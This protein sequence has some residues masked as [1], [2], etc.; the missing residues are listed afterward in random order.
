MSGIKLWKFEKWI[1][2]RIKWHPPKKATSIL[3]SEKCL[4][5]KEVR[6][7]ISILF[8]VEVLAKSISFQIYN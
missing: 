1:D 8:I 3:K 5:A 4:R 6:V 2:R 7:Y